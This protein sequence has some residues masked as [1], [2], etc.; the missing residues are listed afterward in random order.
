MRIFWEY[1]IPTSEINL[2]HHLCHY[3]VA[4]HIFYFLSFLLLAPKMIGWNSKKNRKRNLPEKYADL[5]VL[6]GGKE[7]TDYES[8]L[9]T[10]IDAVL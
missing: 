4:I 6:G 8:I 7:D 10:N 5:L 3:R 2:F 1:I 9:S